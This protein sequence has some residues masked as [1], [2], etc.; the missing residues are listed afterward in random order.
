[1]DGRPVEK[2]WGGGDIMVKCEGCCHLVRGY[3]RSDIKP[4]CDIT[5]EDVDPNEERECE[6]REAVK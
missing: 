1:M 3:A 2:V 6:H 5:Q 4:F